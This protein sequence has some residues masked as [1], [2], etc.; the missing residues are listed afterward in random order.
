MCAAGEHGF[1]LTACTWYQICIRGNV[2]TE[3]IE[4]YSHYSFAYGPITAQLANNIHK[5]GQRMSVCVDT[6]PMNPTKL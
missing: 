5:N 4:W 1:P 2:I 3:A 6:H